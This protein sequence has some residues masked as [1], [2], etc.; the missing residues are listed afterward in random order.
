MF[1][2]LFPFTLHHLFTKKQQIKLGMFLGFY[3]LAETLASITGCWGRKDTMTLVSSVT[4]HKNST[5]LRM[6]E[7]GFI[8][9]P[10]SN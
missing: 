6:V 7:V 1:R 9:N 2:F 3:C 4:F 10:F 5:I 8:H